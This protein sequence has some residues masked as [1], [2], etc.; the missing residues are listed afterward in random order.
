MTSSTERQPRRQRGRRF[1]NGQR[2]AAM[3]AVA[4]ARLLAMNAAGTLAE[5]AAATA[6]NPRAVAA[7]ITVLK[8]GL[9]AG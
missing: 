1:H 9:H 2:V 7:A 6:S 4:G 5:A 3:R 8:T